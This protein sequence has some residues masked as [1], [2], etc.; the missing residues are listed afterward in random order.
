VVSV[1]V[2]LVRARAVRE[3]PRVPPADRAEPARTLAARVEAQVALDK[4]A[5]AA[6]DRTPVPD[7]GRPVAAA[8]DRQAEITPATVA[9]PIPEIVAEQTPEI[10]AARTLAI[11]VAEPQPGA[12]SL[13]GAE[14]LP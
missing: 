14:P 8:P 5:L 13:Q 6:P 1:P 12:I 9:G 3:E 7:L 11:V 10:A 2:A 4:P